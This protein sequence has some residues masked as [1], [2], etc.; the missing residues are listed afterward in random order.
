ME[1]NAMKLLIALLTVLGLGLVGC[2]SCGSAEEAA[3]EVKAEEATEAAPEVKTEE[4]PEKP[5]KK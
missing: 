3:P 5:A 2:E 1:E 4:A